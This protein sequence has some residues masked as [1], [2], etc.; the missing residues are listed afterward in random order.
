MTKQLAN[1]FKNFTMGYK[2]FSI[3]F[4]GKR[5]YVTHTLTTIYEKMQSIKN[6]K[7][8]EIFN[9]LQEYPNPKIILEYVKNEEN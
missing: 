5:V 9:L 2:I 1:S 4:P 3:H 7:D 6:D 8:H